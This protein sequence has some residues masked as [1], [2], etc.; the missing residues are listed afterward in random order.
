MALSTMEDGV[1]LVERPVE[2]NL[3]AGNGIADEP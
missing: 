1:L 2:Q 3:I